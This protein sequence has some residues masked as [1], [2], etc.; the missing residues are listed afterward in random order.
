MTKSFDRF[1][2]RSIDKND[3]QTTLRTKSEDLD[4]NL[5]PSCNNSKIRKREIYCTKPNCG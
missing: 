1:R 5:I 3:D 4:N 2:D